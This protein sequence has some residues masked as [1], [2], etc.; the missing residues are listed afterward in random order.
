MPGFLHQRNHYRTD[1]A[2]VPGD[3]DFHTSIPILSHASPVASC[4]PAAQCGDCNILFNRNR[5]VLANSRSETGL[6]DFVNNYWGY[7]PFRLMSTLSAKHAFHPAAAR[8]N[9]N[10]AIN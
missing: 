10:S 3:Q 9:D 7:G 1:E 4:E 6:A 5:Y 8:R 2:Q